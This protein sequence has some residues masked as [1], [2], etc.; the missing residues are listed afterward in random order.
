MSGPYIITA[1]IVV[2]KLYNPNYGDDSKC[3]CG[4]KYL[5]HFDTC[6]NMEA[7]SCKYCH[8]P[9]FESFESEAWT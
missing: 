9:E 2:E 5:S 4:H 8:C 7:I 3:K 6:K 1:R